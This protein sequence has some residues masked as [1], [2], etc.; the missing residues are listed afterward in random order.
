M[1]LHRK[2]RLRMEN[3]NLNRSRGSRNVSRLSH[4]ELT[5]G[6]PRDCIWSTT[7][8]LASL[9]SI[10]RHS[11]WNHEQRHSVSGSF[12]FREISI[13]ECFHRQPALHLDRQ[14]STEWS[15]P[16]RGNLS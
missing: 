5:I 4:R 14:R 11:A 3:P 16:R 9:E 10:R 12:P 2:V 15:T 7:K 6:K 8:Q 13:P 1:L